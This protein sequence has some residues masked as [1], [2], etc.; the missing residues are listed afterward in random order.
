VQATGI[1]IAEQKRGG[2][3]AAFTSGPGYGQRALAIGSIP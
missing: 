1:H 3:A 2:R